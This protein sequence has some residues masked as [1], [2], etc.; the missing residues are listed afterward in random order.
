[1]G[2]RAAFIHTVTGLAEPFQQLATELL[3]D[4]EVFSL[5]DESL[6]RRTIR[7]GRLETRTMRRLAGLVASV[8]DEG[9]DAIL[10]TCSSLGPA[11]EAARPL[12][13]VPLLRVDEPMVLQAVH[14]GDRIG[15]LATLSTTLEP[16]VSLVEQVAT[17]EGRDVAVTAQLCDGAFEAVTK[18]DVERHDALV[19]AGLERL[20]ARVD[21]VVLAQA[22]MARVV[23]DLPE[24]PPIPVLSS[25]RSSVE[26]LAA[27]LS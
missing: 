11:V 22:S 26:Q 17:R 15:V 16:T 9:V 3:G 23:T 27:V 20:A 5:V 2:K 19:R 8:E 10:V 25:P 13:A 1:M 7:Q 21:V 24:S 18:G 14:G 4:V 12:C 6:L